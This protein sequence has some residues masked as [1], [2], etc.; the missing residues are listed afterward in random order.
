MVNSAIVSPQQ[1]RSNAA[2][3]VRLG[4]A[5]NIS[6]QL[7]TALMSMSRSWTILAGDV[8]RYERLAQAEAPSTPR[9]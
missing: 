1:C 2:E 9:S 8:E 5:A 6:A 7:A 3:C 4:T